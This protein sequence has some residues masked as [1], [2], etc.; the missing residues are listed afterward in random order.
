MKLKGVTAVY[1]KYSFFVNLS[2]SVTE[3]TYKNYS[4]VSAIATVTLD[5]HYFDTT[6]TTE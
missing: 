2:I 5:V 1:K 4:L 3:Q 6:S